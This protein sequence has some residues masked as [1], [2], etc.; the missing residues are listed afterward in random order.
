MP[1][2]QCGDLHRRGTGMLREFCTATLGL[3]RGLLSPIYP[4]FVL[5]DLDRGEDG[6]CQRRLLH[7][8]GQPPRP[9]RDS[10][11]SPQNSQ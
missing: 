2:R 4:R 8:P 3:W 1:S 7:D 10:L 5:E 11:P 9:L 6:L